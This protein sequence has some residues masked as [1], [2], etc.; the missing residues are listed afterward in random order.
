MDN[1][2]YRQGHGATV[3]QYCLPRVVVVVVVVEGSKQGLDE[4]IRVSHPESVSSHSLVRRVSEEAAI[5]Q[6]KALETARESW[7]QQQ[8]KAVANVRWGV[9]ATN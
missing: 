2:C 4:L 7:A 6:E 5:V 8:T 1:T 9:T 3:A